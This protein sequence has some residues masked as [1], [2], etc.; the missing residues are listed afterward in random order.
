MYSALCS[1]G[2]GFGVWGLEFVWASG[3]GFRVKRME[4]ALLAGIVY[5]KGS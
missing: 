5:S 2:L 1:L 3:L 4:V